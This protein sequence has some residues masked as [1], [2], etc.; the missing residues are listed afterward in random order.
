MTTRFQRTLFLSLI[1][2]RHRPGSTP[3]LFCIASGHG[4]PDRLPHID[5]S[6]TE[7][8]IFAGNSRSARRKTPRTYLQRSNGRALR[9]TDRTEE[10]S[11]CESAHLSRLLATRP[12]QHSARLRAYF[13]GRPLMS[14]QKYEQEKEWLRY[15]LELFSPYGRKAIRTYNRITK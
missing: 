2:H 5:S 7:K 9:S 12:A 1:S 11:W 15:P 13:E 3:A 4:E 10:T 8:A 6:S 14:L